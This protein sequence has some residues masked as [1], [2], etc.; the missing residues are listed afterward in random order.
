M[1][2]IITQKRCTKCG[3]V[4]PIGSFGTDRRRADGL[5]YW[6]RDCLNSY[7]RSWG[8]ANPEKMKESNKRYAR[9]HPDRIKA[10]TIGYRNEVLVAYG[11]VCA[12]C[13][14]SRYEFLAID[15]I[16]GNGNRERKEQGNRGG[17]SFYRLLIRNGFPPGY[18]VLCHNCNMSL[19][20]YGYCPHKIEPT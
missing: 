18:R 10:K 8:K 19:G 4:K 3:Q 7:Q 12:C 6:C 9:N 2:N 17:A 13:G 14:E 1:D 5:S 20:A 15:H 16:N 11:G